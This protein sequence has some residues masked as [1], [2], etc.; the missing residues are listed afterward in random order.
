MNQSMSGPVRRVVTGHDADGRAVF[1]D[2]DRFGLVTVP[3]GDAAMTVLWTTD[4]PADNNDEVDGRDRET[5]LTLHGGSVIR[6]LDLFPGRESPMH[7]TSSIDYGIVLT[8]Q[9]ELELDDGVTT[10]V[11]PGDVVVQRGTMHLWRNRS[12][13]ETCRIA[14]ILVEATAA[15]VDGVPLPEVQP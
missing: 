13:T 4:L 10:Q 7:R 3:R 8:G 1:R 6:V 14:F 11:G 9:V 12:D 5:G 2:D 15:L